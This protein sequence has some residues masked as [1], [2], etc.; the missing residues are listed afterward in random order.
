MNFLFCRL[1]RYLLW[2]GFVGMM[3][4]L[5]GVLAAILLID[6]VE[7]IDRKSVV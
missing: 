3:I 5:V 2:R 4:A 6:L 7:Q 1:G